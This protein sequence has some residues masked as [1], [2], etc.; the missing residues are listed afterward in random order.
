VDPYALIYRGYRWF[1]V[2]WCYLREGLRTFRLDRV[3]AVEVRAEIFSRPE[4]FDSVAYLT[5]ALVDAPVTYVLE[6]VLGVSLAEARRRIEPVL[7][8][9]EETP[10]GVVLRGAT[11]DL[12]WWAHLLAGLH[13]PLIIRQ[14]PELRESLRQLG[15]DLTALAEHGVTPGHE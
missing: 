6:V 13:C 2:G 14:P 10:D 7:V 12:R 1:M 8:T 5:N 4:G 3:L 15:N 9:L 11:S